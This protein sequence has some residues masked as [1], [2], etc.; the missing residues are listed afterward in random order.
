MSTAE[1]LEQALDPF[2]NCLTPEAASK[3]VALRADSAMQLR[4]DELAEWANEGLLTP[5]ERAEYEKILALFHLITLLQSKARR[6][7]SALLPRR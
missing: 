2:V 7:L 4:L 6:F 1:L 3:I 5:D